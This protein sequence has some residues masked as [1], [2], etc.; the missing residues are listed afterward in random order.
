MQIRDIM[1]PKV[2]LIAPGAS[3]VEAATRLR[4]DGIGALPVGENDRLVGM[5]TDRDIAIRG[6]AARKS[7]ENATV[8]DLMS[9]GIFW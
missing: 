9:E 1:S 3:M 4:D 6:V 2:D 7:P 8:R 5:I